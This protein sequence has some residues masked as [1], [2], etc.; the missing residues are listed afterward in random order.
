MVNRARFIGVELRIV[1]FRSPVLKVRA[2]S[3]ASS[4][5]QIKANERNFSPEVVVEG[6]SSVLKQ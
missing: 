4:G 6:F 1:G 5:R 2:E 3:K